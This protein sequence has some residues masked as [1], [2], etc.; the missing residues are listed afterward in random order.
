MHLKRVLVALIILPLIF[1]YVSQL[2][3]VF[4]LALIT[5]VAVLAQIE[6]HSMYKVSKAIS[7]I[8]IICGV[9]VLTLSSLNAARSGSDIFLGTFQSLLFIISFILISST[10]LLIKK[11]PAS[12]LRDI[13]PALI[14]ILYIPNLL[15]AQW[16]LRLKGYEWIFLLYGCVW[17]SDSFAYYIGKGMGK[18]K[19]YPEVSPNKTVEGAVGSLLGGT[20]AAMLLGSLMMRELGFLTLVFIGISIGAITI[21]GDLVESMFKRDA[22]VKDSSS[23]IPGHGGVLDK[24]DSALFAGPI[25]YWISRTL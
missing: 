21:V 12:A 9:L 17:V 16:Y 5:V 22:G 25:L 10:R 23:L 13:A 15:V 4:F 11:N 18:S 20:V 14:G 2:P 1:L 8:G 24:I 3:P 6:F 7:F 19:L